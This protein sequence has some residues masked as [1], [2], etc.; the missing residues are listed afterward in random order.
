MSSIETPNSSSFCHSFTNFFKSQ[1]TPR[2]ISALSI[3]ISP[4]ESVFFTTLGACFSILDLATCKDP[5][6]NLELL[7]SSRE[8]I[9]VPYFHLLKTLNPKAEV[10]SM[11]KP[12]DL[13]NIPSGVIAKAVQNAFKGPMK[14]LFESESA[15]KREIVLRLSMPFLATSMAV[16]RVVDTFFSLNVAAGSLITLGYFPEVN[17][18]AFESLQP[19]AAIED[20]FYSAFGFFCPTILIEDWLKQDS[21]AERLVE[22]S[23]V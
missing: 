8:I 23:P 9:A 15:F 13:S 19:T 18:L 2:I 14:D 20:T 11:P 1:V 21:A 10:P 22:D 16:S 5:S 7:K 4:I 3:P 12:G 17:N 6:S